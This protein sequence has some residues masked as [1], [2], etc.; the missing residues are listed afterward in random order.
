M[1]SLGCFY[2]SGLVY[3]N[4]LFRRLKLLPSHGSLEFM[5]LGSEND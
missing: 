1:A 2:D 4:G 3:S 5:A